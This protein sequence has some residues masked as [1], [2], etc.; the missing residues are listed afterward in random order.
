MKFSKTEIVK[1]ENLFILIFLW[2]MFALLSF[3]LLGLNYVYT[4][5]AADEP[6]NINIDKHY[7]PRISIIVPTF[8]EGQIIGYKIKNLSKLEYPKNMMQI[9]FVDSNSTDSTINQIKEFI[10]NNKEK[11]ETKL[12]IEDQRRGK[13]EALNSALKNCDG[14]IVII[15]DADCFWP[16]NM[17]NKAIPYM[18]DPNVGAISGQKRILNLEDSYVTKSENAYLQV[19]SLLRE[20]ESKIS[21]T[22]F[23]EGGFSAFK[24]GIIDCFDPYNTGSDDCGTVIGVL[25]KNYRAIMVPEAEFFTVFPKTWSEKV[26]IKVRRGNQLIRVFGRYAYLLALG[27]I[28]TGKGVVTKNLLVYL[29]A[30]FAFLSLAATTICLILKMPIVM[31]ILFL[32]FAVPKVRD[33]LFEVSLNFLIIL[34]A[35]VLSIFR[36]FVFWSQPK[37]RPLLKEEMLLQRQ[38]I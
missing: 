29:L 1:G 31:V 14:E 8:N 6:W 22:L 18:A 34:C 26:K 35:V 37:D 4:K 25:E 7:L 13:S 16:S 27:K 21:S 2:V 9:I 20:G 36:K 19:M 23:F 24:R 10:D 30:P 33:L 28:K 38:L 5:R 17:L 15:S 12:I 11:V 3:G 32:L